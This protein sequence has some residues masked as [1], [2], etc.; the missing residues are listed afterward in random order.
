M[1]W[2]ILF[3]RIINFAVS[4]SMVGIE[5]NLKKYLSMIFGKVRSLPFNGS[6]N[7]QF[8]LLVSAVE[9]LLFVSTFSF[10]SS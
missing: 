9:F 6:K 2:T 7:Q 4:I 8:E 3:S 1:G 5:G 10:S